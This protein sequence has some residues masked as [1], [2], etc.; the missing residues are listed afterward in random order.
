[1]KRVIYKCRLCNGT[2]TV[3]IG[4]KEFPL[5]ASN[6]LLDLASRPNVSQTFHHCGPGRVG[7]ADLVGIREHVE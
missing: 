6:T 1:M 7:L 5:L 2:K 4:Q 3:L